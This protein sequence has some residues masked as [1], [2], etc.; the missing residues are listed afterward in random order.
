MMD[1]NCEVTDRDDHIHVFLCLV[2]SGKSGREQSLTPTLVTVAMT[3]LIKVN[4]PRRKQI[5]VCTSASEL[6]LF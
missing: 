1:G 2:I 4:S 6:S 3:S 5:L